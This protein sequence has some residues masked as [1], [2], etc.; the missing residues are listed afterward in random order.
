MR[1]RIVSCSN[2]ETAA[3]IVW[4]LD[5]FGRS[6]L[7]LLSNIRTPY[8]CGVR[9]IRTSQGIDTDHSNAADRL[10][11]NFRVDLSRQGPPAR[12]RGARAGFAGAGPTARTRTR[13]LWARSVRA[14]VAG[15]APYALHAPLQPFHPRQ[16]AAPAGLAVKVRLDRRLVDG[17]HLPAVGERG[18]D[19]VAADAARAAP[20]GGLAVAEGEH[21]VAAARRDRAG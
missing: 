21:V 15:R 11:L 18:L 8:R 7:D 17:E 1:S 13:R 5:R 6:N 10:L 3:V 9:F 4:R 19:L 12:P 2:S 20:V 16:P 14:R